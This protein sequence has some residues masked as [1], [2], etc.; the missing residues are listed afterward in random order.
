[1]VQ[2]RPDLVCMYEPSRKAGCLELG[3]VHLQAKSGVSSLYLLKRG[4]FRSFNGAHFPH[5]YCTLFGIN[6]ASEKNAVFRDEA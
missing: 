6:S 1:V 3:S 5:L 2:T 4:A